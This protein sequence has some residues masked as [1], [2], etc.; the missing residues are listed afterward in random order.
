[1]PTTVSV[2]PASEPVSLIE[3][4]SFLRVDDTADNTLLSSLITSARIQVEQYLRRAL[5][6]QTLQTIVE[7]P[8]PARGPISG[9]VGAF[10]L[11]D[12]LP[13][14]RATI[15]LPHPPLQSVTSVHY[16]DESSYAWILVDATTY[17]VDTTAVP[18]MLIPEVEWEG[19]RLKVLYVAGYGLAAA[20][21][22]PIKYMILNI[23]SFRYANREGQ[24]LPK[25]LFKIAES[26]R[27]YYL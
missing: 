11:E 22:D 18:G 6:T 17:T 13:V 21:P 27:I 7:V 19:P 23:V 12:G 10:K 4:K 9:I 16:W 3:A 15:E 5:V 8:V 14:T 20:V 25:D 24:E 2:A 1:M 26:Y